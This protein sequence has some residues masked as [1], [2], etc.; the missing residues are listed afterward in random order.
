MAKESDERYTPDELMTLVRTS[1]GAFDDVCGVGARDGLDR[2]WGESV[3]CNPPGSL[4]TDFADMAVAQINAGNTRWLIWCAFN[5]DHSTRWWHTIDTL[6]PT[7]AI[8]RRRWRF[9]APDGR[10][11]DVGRSQAFA[12]VG[13]MAKAHWLPH[14]TL[15]GRVTP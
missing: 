15:M 10:L 7:W 13:P 3:Y 8:M 14:A 2:D 9:T 6:C 4:M 1:L 12:L 5:W 11:V